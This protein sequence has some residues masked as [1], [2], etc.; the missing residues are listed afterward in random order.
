MILNSIRWRLQVW[1]GLILL[2]VLAGFGFTAYRLEWNRRMRTLDEGLQKRLAALS[3]VLGQPPGARGGAPG[4]PGGLRP[5]PEFGPEIRDD[6]NGRPRFRG[7]PE[8]DA[9]PQEGRPSGPAGLGIAPLPG[10]VR[11][12]ARIAAL[13]DDSDTN[14]FYYV[15]WRRDGIELARSSNAPPGV[16]K[17]PRLRSD[18]R[19][20]LVMAGNFRQL[21]H[22]TPP[23]E[24]IAA[25]RS[26]APEFRELQR[27]A[28]TLAGVGGSIL[29]L[30]LAGGWWLASRA[31]RPI[32]DIS[33]TASK[34]SAG[35]LAQ[36]INAAAICFRRRS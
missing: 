5:R 18:E 4:G 32:Q 1:Y 19:P 15:L 8:A 6:Q 14:G 13:F 29:L 31:I 30:G 20:A 27:T 36:R 10:G 3:S 25:G 22:F 16:L 23:G 2:F 35:D 9:P 11:L 24:V 28:W 33:A 26:L 12:P 34:I 7:P 17:P 21:C